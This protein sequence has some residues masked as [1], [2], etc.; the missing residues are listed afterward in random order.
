MTFAETI[1][2][3]RRRGL[4]V[5]RTE[6][7]KL[8]VVGLGRIDE[9]LAHELRRHRGAFLDLFPSSR[10]RCFQIVARALDSVSASNPPDWFGGASAWATIEELEHA[11]FS[12]ARLADVERTKATAL[13]Y[14]RACLHLFTQRTV[15]ERCPECGFDVSQK[16]QLGKCR[17]L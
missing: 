6:N 5:R 15:T 14:E 2:L 16:C 13:E 4:R 17:S 10:E 8:H 1:G 3:L 12:A 7:D 9:S 11:M